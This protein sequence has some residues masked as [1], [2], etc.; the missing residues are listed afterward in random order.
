MYELKRLPS[1]S[2]F[3]L[4]AAI[5]SETT[6]AQSVSDWSVTFAGFLRFESDN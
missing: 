4:R 2:A 1:R 5:S 6:S 3:D